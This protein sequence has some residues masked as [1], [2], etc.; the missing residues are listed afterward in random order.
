MKALWR[1][2]RKKEKEKNE[3]LQSAADRIVIK[4]RGCHLAASVYVSG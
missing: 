2:S 4:R 3:T 1:D